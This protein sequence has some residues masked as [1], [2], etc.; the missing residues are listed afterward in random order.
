MP[1]TNVYEVKRVLEA[2]PRT[3]KRKLVCPNCGWTDAQ[4]KKT[5]LLGCPLCYDVFGITSRRAISV[6]SLV[7]S[8]SSDLSQGSV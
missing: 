1:K 6:E 5:E 3:D 2:M 4:R 8:G 7:S